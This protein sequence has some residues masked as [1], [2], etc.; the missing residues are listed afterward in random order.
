MDHIAP[1]PAPHTTLHPWGG[2]LDRA[3]SL[4]AS[5]GGG[6]LDRAPRCIPAASQHQGDSP[7]PLPTSS[8]HQGDTLD[9]LPAASQ[10]Q[11]DT[12]D[13]APPCMSW[14][15]Q[16]GPCSLLHP[17]IRGPSRTTLPPASRISQ[18]KGAHWFPARPMESPCSGSGSTPRLC[19]PGRAACREGMQHAED[20][21]QNNSTTTACSLEHKDHR[22]GHAEGQQCLRQGWQDPSPALPGPPALSRWQSDSQA[23]ELGAHRGAGDCKLQPYGNGT[24]P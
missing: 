7:D 23:A 3:V 4:H 24:V 6:R 5:L 12:L 21:Q 10:H 8:Q 11:R 13:H 14:G 20:E 19:T 16:L 2:S 9:L 22:S 1:P 17:S 15:W 18:S